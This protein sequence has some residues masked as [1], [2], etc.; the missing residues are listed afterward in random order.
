MMDKIAKELVQIAKLLVSADVKVKLNKKLRNYDEFADVL[1]L[2]TSFH[3]EA[4]IPDRFGVDF[5]YVDKANARKAK[6]LID[7]YI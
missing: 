6:E 5:I 2:L 1:D 3:I 7:K 4:R